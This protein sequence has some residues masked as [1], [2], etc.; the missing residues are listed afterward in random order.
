V[1]F[2][3][4]IFAV[5]DFFTSLR[6]TSL[7][8]SERFFSKHQWSWNNDPEHQKQTTFPTSQVLRPEKE[9]SAQ[10]AIRAT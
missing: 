7:T 10:T 5:L 1:R 6:E 4:E 8:P 9:T 3:P 2:S